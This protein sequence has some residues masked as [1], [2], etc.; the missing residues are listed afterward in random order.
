MPIE[1][2][3]AT[4]EELRLAGKIRYIGFSEVTGDEL[5]R[6]AA[7]CPVSAIQ[8]EYSL[9]SREIEVK[10][11]PTARELGVGIVAY[12][13]LGRGVLSRT[14]A[15][16]ADLKEGDWRAALPRIADDAA[17]AANF[18]AAERLEV[19]ATSLNLAPAT[20]A[21]GWVLAQGNDVFPIPGSKVVAR[22]EQNVAAAHVHLTAD[23]IKQIEEAV[24]IAVGA[25]YPTANAAS[26]FEA[27]EKL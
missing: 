11:I 22:L 7:I 12:S 17:A 23:V 13:P 14:F 2:V 26:T 8:M 16:K 25:R 24:P 9:Q 21:L 27:R 19:L 15:G 18:A 20:L 3:A 1:D 5:K 6:A 4:L 10:V